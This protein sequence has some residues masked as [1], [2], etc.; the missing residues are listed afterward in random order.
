MPTYVPPFATLLALFRREPDQ[1]LSASE[2]DLH[3]AFSRLLA[4]LEVD[5]GWYL[6][7]YDDVP[8]GI[9]NGSIQSARQHFLE[10]GYFEGRMPHPI[11]V[12]ERW[13]LTTYPD[14]AEGVR[15]GRLQ[16]GQQHFDENGY[17]E[18]RL[19]FKL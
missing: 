16:S 15:R 14:V 1:R 4:S 10:H 13:Y 12:D 3:K 9:A 5:E 11:A 19:P 6:A 7:R 18:G 2:E 8:R 17:K